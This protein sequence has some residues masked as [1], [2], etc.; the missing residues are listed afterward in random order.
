M[1]ISL[2]I[3]LAGGPSSELH[4]CDQTS[5]LSACCAD[6]GPERKGDFHVEATPAESQSRTT[7][8]TSQGAIEVSAE[9]GFRGLDSH[10]R[11][12]PLF[13]SHRFEIPKIPSAKGVRERDASDLLPILKVF[14]VKDSTLPLD[15]RSD[16]Q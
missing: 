8:E 3:V 6:T 11:E 4:G 15:C 12:Q 5:L 16:D 10:W 7:Q 9:S 13:P 2:P 1:A 14:T